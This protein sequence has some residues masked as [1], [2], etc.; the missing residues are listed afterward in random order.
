MTRYWIWLASRPNVPDGLKC[1]LTRAFPDPREVFRA[2]RAALREIPGMTLQA[3]EALM[4]RDLTGAE[5]ILADCARL[6]IQILTIR[7][8]RYPDRLRAV[9]DAPIVLYYKGCLPEMNRLA[10]IAVVGTRKASVY[11]LQIAAQMGAALARGGALVVSGLAAG[12]DAAAMSGALGEG[13]AAVGVLGCGADIVYPKTNQKLFR[14]T[15]CQGCILTEYAPGTPPVGWHFPKRNRIISGLSCG[16]VVVEAPERSGALLTARLA[17]EHGRDVFVV[18]GN[19]DM[20]GFVGSNRL[21]RDGAIAVSTGQDVLQDY[22]E[23]YPGRLRKVSSPEPVIREASAEQPVKQGK[24]EPVPEK[25][26]EKAI[27]KG[28]NPPYSGPEDNLAALSPEERQILSLIEKEM[29]VDEVIAAAGRNPGKT[30]GVLTMLELKG[31][32]CR[33]PGKRVARRR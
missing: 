31:K 15:E 27:D 4:D 17:L 9:F 6:G 24:K 29:L 1:A 7:D 14:Q 25:S 30:L 16:V 23:I 13:V 22:G 19:V 12:I 10:T 32:I 5:K 2:S 21:L 8:P 20:P 33:L 26:T 28:A 11:G 18:P 3:L